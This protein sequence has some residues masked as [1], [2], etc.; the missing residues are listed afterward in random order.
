[1]NLVWH[2]DFCN[3]DACVLLSYTFRELCLARMTNSTAG[4]AST[5]VNYVSTHFLLFHVRMTKSTTSKYPFFYISTSSPSCNGAPCTSFACTNT[6]PFSVMRCKYVWVWKL[7]MLVG[8]SWGRHKWRLSMTSFW[9][10]RCSCVFCMKN[11]VS[12]WQ[13]SDAFGYL[14][15]MT[16][17]GVMLAEHDRPSI[18]PDPDIFAIHICLDEA[19]PLGLVVSCAKVPYSC[20]C[21]SCI[22]NLVSKANLHYKFNFSC[23]GNL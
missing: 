12:A 4:A 18:L 20:K 3:T 5:L 9:L 16:H 13:K 10:A 6:S 19:E 8:E 11:R 2:E 21:K 7:V 22:T 15:S 14:T 17:F 23:W 1:M